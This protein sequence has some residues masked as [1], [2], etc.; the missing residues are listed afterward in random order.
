MK[1]KKTTKTSSA[2]L[3]S[4]SQKVELH[5]DPNTNN[6]SIAIELE[7]PQFLTGY[8]DVIENYVKSYGKKYKIDVFFTVNNWSSCNMW[9]FTTNIPFHLVV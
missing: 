1:N 5:A 6:L 9:V 3:S 7:Y 4:I 2:D 8:I